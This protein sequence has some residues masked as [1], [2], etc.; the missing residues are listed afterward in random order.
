M[1]GKKATALCA[2]EGGGSSQQTLIK[3]DPARQGATVQ[4][5]PV[6]WDK[7][8]T[9][10]RMVVEEGGGCGERTLLTQDRGIAA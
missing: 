4:T 2:W 6:P 5:Q 8:I 1:Q 3:L 10:E 9:P 7:L